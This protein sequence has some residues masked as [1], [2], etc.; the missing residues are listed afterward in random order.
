[1]SQPSSVSASR[2]SIELASS[3]SID[4][5]SEGSAAGTFTGGTGGGTVFDFG[6]GGGRDDLAGTRAMVP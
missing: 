3:A 2:L 5:G 1:M 6:S 4:F